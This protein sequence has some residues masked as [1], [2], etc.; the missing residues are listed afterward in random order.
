MSWLSEVEEVGAWDL[1]EKGKK[2]G[3]LAKIMTTFSFLI[4]DL[5][6]L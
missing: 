3:K 2:G 6:V 5:Q 1:E 4:L